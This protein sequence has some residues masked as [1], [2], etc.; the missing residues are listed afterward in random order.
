M[1]RLWELPDAISIS[2]VGVRNVHRTSGHT[3]KSTTSRR[4]V[5]SGRSERLTSS[6]DDTDMLPM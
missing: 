3:I 6:R 2:A 5:N 1:A 4:T